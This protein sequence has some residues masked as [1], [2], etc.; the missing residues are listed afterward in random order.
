[1]F[2][3]RNIKVLNRVLTKKIRDFLFSNKF[4]EILFF[5]FFV[6]IASVFWL[7]NTLNYEHDNEVSVRLDVINLPENYILVSDNPLYVKVKI[8]D[9]GIK[10]LNYSLKGKEN[11]VTVDMSEVLLSSGSTSFRTDQYLKSKSLFS[12]E[13][14]II[15]CMPDSFVVNY[16]NAMAVHLPVV[17]N[18][19]VVADRFHFIKNVTVTPDSIVAYVPDNMKEKITSVSTKTIEACELA[20]S[21]SFLVPLDGGGR[22]KLVPEKVNVHYEVGVYTDYSLEIPVTAINFPE[23]YKLR[24]FPSAVKVLFQIGMDEIE[25]TGPDDFSVTLD[26]NDLVNLKSDKTP[27]MVSSS[28][29]NVRNV[30]IEPETVEFLIEKEAAW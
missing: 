23:G 7:L 5:L 6:F 13:T 10:L 4:R 20:D 8:K 18:S 30:R 29:S 16:A 12:Q 3:N 21:A 15:S 28:P 14:N 2:D 1:M 19:D 26:Y 22:I 11:R 24:T 25:Y 27:V 17:I 9:K